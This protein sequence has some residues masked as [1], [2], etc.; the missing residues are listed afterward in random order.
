M[1]LHLGYKCRALALGLAALLVGASALAQGVAASAPAQGLIISFRSAEV[2]NDTEKIDRSPR[3]NQREKA[4]ARWKAATD[5]TRERTRRLAR[6]VGLTAGETG[7]AGNAALLKFKR[8]LK[9]R[10]LEDA[11]RRVRLHPDVAW[12]EPDVLV[13]RLQVPNDSLFN[14]QWHLAA[15][16]GITNFSG[17][18]MPAAWSN[19]T[20]SGVV[21]AVV[22]SGVRPDHPDLVGK[23]L[24]GYDLVSEL[25]VANDGNG[26]DPDPRDPGDWI[27]AG[28]LA[29]PVFAGCD[30][31]NSS[32]HGTFIA[33]QIAAATNTNA[34]G[35]AG[36]NW[37][38]QILPV[39]VSGKCGAL[40]SDLLDGVRWAA[41][42][43]V[44]GVPANANPARVINLSFGGDQPCSPAYQSTI[45]A[46][47]NAGAL[48]VVAAGNRD[49]TLTRPADCRRVMTVA[50]VRKD[51]AKA[52][53]SSF[54]GRVALAAPGGSLAPVGSP[55]PDTDWLLLST[56]NDGLTDPGLDFYG[57]KQGTSFSAP[58][59]AGVA[60]LMLAVNPLLS[61]RQLIE[62]MKAGA[63]PHETLVG[64]SACGTPRA[65]P[66]NCTNATCGAGMLDANTSVQLATGPA[67]VIQPIA[68]VEPGT[69]I[70]LDGSR[71]VAI[72]GASIV[73][74]QWIQ[75]SGPAVTINSA[76][77]AVATATLVSEANYVFSLTA[78]DDSNRRGEDTVQAVAA[79][80]QLAAG[81]GGGSSSLLW[82]LA[83]WAWVLAV[84]WQQYPRRRK[85]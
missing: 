81:G 60:S 33:G 25:S 22:D 55:D 37:N 1:F 65:G 45:D 23:L 31:A 41:G 28:D 24:L 76:S 43:P 17:L 13:P 79:M 39:R 7:E 34:Q 73:S 3:A 59:A 47:T 71:S 70:T 4:R 16:N 72:P 44:S 26:R 78:V 35:V 63:R 51:G 15:P 27:D 52:E 69:V 29:N 32:W 68:Q 64:L 67:V 20:G 75:V 21:V 48:V 11:M 12:V 14:L 84:C 80:P 53:Y 83:L 56:D 66:C 62:R 9:G 42:L 58:Q 36:L 46:V 77:N 40:V 50:S 2:D 18:N 8:P 6:D 54:G 19:T 30:I 61:P 49:N 82:G 74:Y 5:Q 38:A 85:A 10:S 57:H